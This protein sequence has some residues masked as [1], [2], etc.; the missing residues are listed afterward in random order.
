MV[1]SAESL[2]EQMEAAAAAM[3]FEEARRLRDMISLMRAG[4]TAEDAATAD[5]SGITRQRPGAMGLGTSRQRMEPPP[6]WT[7][8]TKPDPMTRGRSRRR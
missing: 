5:L 3:D 8:P 4:V 6:G 2:R 1:E 7:P